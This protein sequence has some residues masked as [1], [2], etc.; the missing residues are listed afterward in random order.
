L[1]EFIDFDENGFEI[2][3]FIDDD[4]VKFRDFILLVF[5]NIEGIVF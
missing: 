4:Y 5:K 1:C 3:R 2:F